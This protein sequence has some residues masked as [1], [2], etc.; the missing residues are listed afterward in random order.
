MN[1]THILIAGGQTNDAEE[2]SEA[3]LVHIEM[4]YSVRLPDMSEPRL[5]PACIQTD[6][7]EVILAGW[8]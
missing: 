7:G 4:G 1:Q 6:S 8:Q 5:S 2:S 3:W